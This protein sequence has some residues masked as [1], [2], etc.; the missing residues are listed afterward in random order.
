MFYGLH[1]H[2]LIVRHWQR[3]RDILR[4]IEA[5]LIFLVELVECRKQLIVKRNNSFFDRAEFHKINMDFHLR[6]IKPE[7][8]S[9]FSK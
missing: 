5:G 6:L 1:L 3:L 9:F 8:L 4:V 2:F 7:V